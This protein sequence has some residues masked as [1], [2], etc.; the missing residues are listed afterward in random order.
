MITIEVENGIVVIKG[1]KEDFQVLADYKFI[2][3][4]MLNNGGLS[5]AP[6]NITFKIVT[7]V[8]KLLHQIVGNNFVT[9]FRQKFPEGE[10]AVYQKPFRGN[11]KK[12]TENMAKF[13]KEF[14]FSEETILKATENMVSRHVNSGKKDYIPQAHYFIYKR[15]R[16]SDLATECEN[17]VNGGSVE[18]FTRYK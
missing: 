8:D 12:V 5:L 4:D 2:T 18:Q 16:G 13:K 1:E 10:S 17:V 14:K 3:Q 7:D 15:D 9:E 11:L 6:K